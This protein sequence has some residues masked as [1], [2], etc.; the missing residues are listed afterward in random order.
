MPS[1]WEPCVHTTPPSSVAPDL[2]HPIVLL[3]AAPLNATY[4]LVCRFA[5]GNIPQVEIPQALSTI[6]DSPDYEFS[7][8]QLPD[9]DLR[10]WVERLD[11]VGCICLHTAQCLILSQIIDSTI[12]TEQ[13]QKRALRSLRK[14][15]GLRGVLPRSHY[16]PG[17]LSKTSRYPVS[18][19]SADVWR[20]E[21]DRKRTFAA[22]VFRANEGDSRKTK[23][24]IPLIA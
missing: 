1:A 20:V 22:K 10:K 17:K 15:C 8:Q 21:D 24:S 19:G 7:I 12:C 2:F 14:T 16:F 5:R 6:F 3:M 9:E 11:Q 23:V 18:G 4:E 13:L